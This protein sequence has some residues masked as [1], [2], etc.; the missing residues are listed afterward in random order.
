MLNKLEIM[1]KILY[2]LIALGSIIPSLVFAQTARLQIIH[3]SADAAASSVDIYVNGA[4]TYNDV[5]FRTATAFADVPAGVPLNVGIAP[6]TSAS[7][8]DTIKNFPVTFTANEKYVVVADGII[9][10]SGYSP[11]TPFGLSVYGMGREAATN[12]ANTDVLVHHGATD[13]LT[14]DVYETGVGAGK[15]VD[16]AA[17][18]DFAGYLELATNDYT[19]EV[20]DETGATTVAS[21]SAPLKTLS[22]D[23]QAVVV[24]AS[25]FLNPANNS[26]G[27]AFG[28]YVALPTGGALVALPPVAA[29]TARLQ[30][31]HNSAD[32]AADSVDIYVNGTLTY[33]NVT[34]RS[35]TA[36]T[37]VPAG[38]TLNVG[39]APAT[40]SSVNDTIKNFPV[41]LTTNKKYIAIAEGIV[42]ASGY[43]PATPFGLAI[44][45]MGREMASNA[46]NTDVLVHHGASDAPTVDV[47]ETGVGAGKIVDNAAYGD[48][49]GYLELAT[50]DYTLEVRDETGA[51]T[52]ASYS[53]PL[54]TLSLDSQAVVVVASGFLNPTNN[55]NG[56]AFGLYVALPTGGALVA[57]PAVAATTARLQII[58]N[59]ADAAADSV[60]IYVNGA[61][62][63]N[64]ITFRSAT[65]FSYVPAGVTLNV[66]IAPAM[67]SSV[68]DTLVNFPVTFTTNKTYIVIADG[69]ISAT[70]Y[71]PAAPFGLAVYDMGREA[72]TNAANTDVL[73]HHGA[74]DAPTV[75]VYETGVGAGMIIDDLSYK[76]FAGYLELATNDYTLEVRDETGSNTVATYSAP[77]STLNLNGKAIVVVASGFLN[78][79]NNS[80]GAAFGLY[81]ALPTGGSL[82]PLSTPVTTSL[83]QIELDKIGFY[84]NPARFNLTITGVRLAD[85]AV[86]ISDITGRVVGN[87]TYSVVGNQINIASLSTGMYQAVLSNDTGDY[88]VLRFIKQ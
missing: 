34:F 70:G 30:I 28:L 84:P 25:G 17:Y 61:L 10:A 44:Y 77:L 11:A 85:Y 86:S 42:S 43:S 18:G 16:N 79:A 57:L 88:K 76:S 33:D 62:T 63:Y 81:V 1:K 83:E 75:D 50:N 6:S 51:T 72:A 7:V 78:P 58:H 67:S 45:D 74:T 29:T 66:G 56:A 69:N 59:S 35:A 19:L 64:D 2:Q 32:A 8:N 38:V 53:A 37:Y 21:Y 20:R 46:A 48:F 24:V 5:N 87:S 52:V 39:I 60:D 71:S 26:N 82:V 31:I 3:N 65:A 22:L 40:S 27:P 55:S 12:S 68:N 14:V 41:T 15:I 49:A 80:N 54:K 13:A 9:S 73:V 4:L 23:S 36:F 47:Y